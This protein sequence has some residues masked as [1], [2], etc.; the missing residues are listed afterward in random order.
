MNKILIDAFGGDNAPEAIIEGSIL[1]L[2]E[3]GDFIAV[4][5]GKEEKIKEELSKYSFDENRVEIIN[6]TEVITC[7][8][9]PTVAIRRKPDSSICVAINKLRTDEQMK[10]FVSAGSTGAVLVGATLKLG[11][12][13]G[14]NRPALTTTL[15]T[16]IRDKRTVFLDT[17]ANADC[18]PINLTQFA[19][20]GSEYAKIAFGNKNPK[21]GL[22]SNGTEDEKGNALNH[23]VFPL[24]KEMQ[25]I[26]F[27]GNVEAR[28]IL[29]GDV[30]VVVADGFAGNVAIK[31]MEGAVQSIL[32]LIK[33]G[34]GASFK[35]KIGGLL[36]KDMFKDLKN[37]LDYNAQGGAVL[38]GANKLVV[39][40]HGS[41]GADTIK[42][43][44]NMAVDM[45]NANLTETIKEKISSKTCGE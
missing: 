39:K 3:R 16:V 27:I 45:A 19:L 8:E 24:L 34:V 44:I 30:D 23:E 10:A 6:A 32:K 36:L 5:V 12:I 35:N 25:D 33:E 38:L 37:R 31:S 40:S 29:T 9:E 7:E 11:R 22:L 28:D 15:P 4:F 14:V 21:V 20:M 26:N 13:N 17:G 42:A 18:K 2:K 43:S 41:S 1:A